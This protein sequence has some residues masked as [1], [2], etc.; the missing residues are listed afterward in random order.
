MRRSYIARRIHALSKIPLELGRRRA[1]YLPKKQ[2]KNEKRGAI[3]QGE[4]MMA[5]MTQPK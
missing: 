4:E 1:W 5:G 3:R 2:I